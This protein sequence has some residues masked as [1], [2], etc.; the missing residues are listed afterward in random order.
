METAVYH[1]GFLTRK[2]QGLSANKTATFM[3]LVTTV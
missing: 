1:T 2:K 3:A